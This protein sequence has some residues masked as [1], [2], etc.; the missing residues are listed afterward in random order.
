MIEKIQEACMSWYQGDTERV[1][2]I[3]I[4]AG[5]WTHYSR[6]IQEALRPFADD[7]GPIYELH[8]SN[9]HKREEWR[10]VSVISPLATGILM[11][12]GADVY[13]LGVRAAVD[14]LKRM[15]K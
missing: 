1:D 8:M 6:A 4:N 3:L 10:H 7:C 11:G 14:Y 13:T 12:M 2:A 9:T 5:A 15:R